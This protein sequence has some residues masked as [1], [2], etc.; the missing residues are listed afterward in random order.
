MGVS[1]SFGVVVSSERWKQ[2]VG[3]VA[4]LRLVRLEVT[5]FDGRLVWSS[6]WGRKATVRDTYRNASI[7]FLHAVLGVLS[8]MF[9]CSCK[10]DR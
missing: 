7:A 10:L 6:G 8:S 9:M 4:S 3:I 5:L 1:D 2:E